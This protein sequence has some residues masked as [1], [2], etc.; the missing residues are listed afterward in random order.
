MASVMSLHFNM[1][2]ED[3][4]KHANGKKCSHLCNTLVNM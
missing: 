2:K 3:I 4:L 1:Q